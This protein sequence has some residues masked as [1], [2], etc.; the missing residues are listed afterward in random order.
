[1]KKVKS[2]YLRVEP[3][4]KENFNN[5]VYREIN[6]LVFD[7]IDNFQI[8][9][10]GIILNPSVSKNY[11]SVPIQIMADMPYVDYQELKNKWIEICSKSKYDF[12]KASMAIGVKL[13]KNDK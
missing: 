8:N 2:I 4:K 5:E 10:C 9:T 3:I 7:V 1:M 6:N 12:V 13:Y 11:V